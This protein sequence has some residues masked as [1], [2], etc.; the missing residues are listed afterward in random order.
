[1]FSSPYELRSL[2]FRKSSFSSIN[3]SKGEGL[4]D[5]FFELGFL[6]NLEDFFIDGWDFLPL[7]H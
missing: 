7:R 5:S 2:I 1:M 4:L 6:D 3:L